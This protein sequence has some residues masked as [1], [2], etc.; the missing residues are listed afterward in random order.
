MCPPG[1]LKGRNRQTGSPALTAPPHGT[2]I[3]VV[4]TADRLNTPVSTMAFLACGASRFFSASAFRKEEVVK[5]L[6]TSPPSRAAPV[7]HA[8]RWRVPPAPRR[9][10]GELRI[11]EA[12]AR[13]FAGARRARPGR[14]ARCYRSTRRPEL[15]FFQRSLAASRRLPAPT[16]RT[17]GSSR[18]RRA[19]GRAS[20]FPASRPRRDHGGRD[21]AATR[22]ETAVSPRANRDEEKGA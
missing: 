12:R 14:E 9:A 10:R 22:L 8:R 15:P 20:R 6:M 19:T 13:P 1:S 18:A 4:H 16:G 3:S 17:R 11:P 2:V 7:V 21:R 5:L